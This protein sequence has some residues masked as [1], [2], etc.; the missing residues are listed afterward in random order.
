V[1]P[2]AAAAAAQPEP[3]PVEAQAPPVLAAE[4]TPTS[5]TPAPVAPQGAVRWAVQPGS[6]LTFGSS[7]SGT[8]IR[9]RFD[10]WTA[11]IVFGPDALDTSKVTVSV[12]LASVKTGDPQRDATLPSSDWFDVGTQA[13]AIF[14]A[15]RFTKAG[16]GRFVAH[17][18]L[19]L[20]GVSKPL[21]LP[22]RLT[23][24]G[25][26]AQAKG[27]ASL[28]RGDFKVGEGEFAATDQI[29]GQV[30]IDIDVKAK[31]VP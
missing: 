11:D 25:D 7:W 15:S 5:S 24:D 16:E 17:G 10:H 2:P 3:A 12:D 20:K 21:D 31:R 26:Q 28:V 4:A 27:H 6:S 29:P 23:I 22:F 19:K 1:A 14:T 8:P 30:T 9:G 18:T 13:K